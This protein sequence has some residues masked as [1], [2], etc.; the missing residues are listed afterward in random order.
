[1]SNYVRTYMYKYLRII[2]MYVYAERREHQSH[3]QP[4]DPPS[5]TPPGRQVQ[6]RSLVHRQE[7]PEAVSRC[8]VG[9]RAPLVIPHGYRYMYMDR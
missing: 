2:C 6:E 4:K 9:E 7:A 5:S 8:S 3:S 1:M